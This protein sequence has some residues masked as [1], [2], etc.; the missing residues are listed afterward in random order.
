LSWRTLFQ[1]LSIAEQVVKDT[2]FAN[3]A[4][5]LKLVTSIA[6]VGTSMRVRILPDLH[7]ALDT[8]F[9]LTSR[10]APD[11]KKTAIE[12]LAGDPAK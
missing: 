1:N 11:D 10:R 8:C 3:Y 2:F 12:I 6:A 7:H 5:T 4:D 9:V